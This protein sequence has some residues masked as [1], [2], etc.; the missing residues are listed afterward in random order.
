MS[1][2]RENDTPPVNSSTRTYLMSGAAL[3]VGAVLGGGG[4]ALVTNPTSTNTIIPE[5]VTYSACFA[6]AS[7]GLM[8]VDGCWS[9][10]R[11]SELFSTIH[12]SEGK[13]DSKPSV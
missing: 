7:A 9:V 5:S 8:L 1:S 13:T 12:T 10:L 6:N 4:T 11:S 2:T 3:A